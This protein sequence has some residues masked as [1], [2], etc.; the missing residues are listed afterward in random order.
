MRRGLLLAVFLA[1][2]LLMYLVP[3]TILRG[4]EPST[5]YAYWTLIALAAYV[6]AILELRRWR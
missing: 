6:A 3:Y 1:F 2:I 4:A 5:L